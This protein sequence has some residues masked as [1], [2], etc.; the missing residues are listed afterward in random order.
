MSILEQWL[1]KMGGT[2]ALVTHEVNSN[3][4]SWYGY[5]RGLTVTLFLGKSEVTETFSYSSLIPLKDNGY[6]GFDVTG[7]AQTAAKLALDIL[8][9]RGIKTLFIESYDL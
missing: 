6:G 5:W 3:C 9:N 2:E 4:Q 8:K 7:Q 1:T